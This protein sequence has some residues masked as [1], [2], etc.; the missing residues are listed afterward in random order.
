VANG[1]ALTTGIPATNWPTYVAEVLRVL[2]PNTGIAL[3]IELNPWLK[4]DDY[5]ITDSTP[6]KQV[7]ISQI[8][9]T[10]QWEDI[11]YPPIEQ[12]GMIFGGHRLEEFVTSAGFVDV[13]VNKYKMPTS[14][15][16]AGISYNIL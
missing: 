14:S 12:K 6:L 9:L 1:R 16:P 11:V 10:P 4:S 5:N 8:Q 13:K 2:K 15:W 3:F 7:S